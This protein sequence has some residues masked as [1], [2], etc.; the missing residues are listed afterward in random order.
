MAMDAWIDAPR[1]CFVV[2]PIG[3]QGTERF[4]TFRHVLERLIRPAVEESSI[5]LR[6]IRADDIHRPG[7]F[8]RDV[9]EYLAGAYLVVVDLTGQNANVFYELGVRHALSPRT[10]LIARATTDIPADLR[11]Y[12]TLIYSDTPESDDTF[13]ENLR[14]YLEEIEK[15]PDAPDNPVLSWLKLPQIPDD[16][17]RSFTARLANA[18]STQP[19]ILRFVQNATG[20]TGTSI[21]QSDLESRFQKSRAEMY[22]RLEQL[23][24]LGFLTKE[25]L[26]SDQFAYRLA[27]DYRRELGFPEIVISLSL[28]SQQGRARPFGNSADAPPAYFYYVK[29]NNLRTAAIYKTRIVVTRIRLFDGDGGV[30][31]DYPARMQLKWQFATNRCSPK[32]VNAREEAVANLGFV[33]KNHGFFQLDICAD[34]WPPGFPARLDPRRRMRVDLMP[35]VAGAL[36]L[37]GMSL[38]IAWDGTWNDDAAQMEGNLVIK[39]VSNR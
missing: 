16:L 33:I 39:R 11:E 29:A 13:R 38:E 17:R 12:R 26:T 27:P 35:E 36:T 1:Q 6:V 28:V 25:P 14:H 22:Y 21:S 4:E 9:L 24:L 8:I 20:A 19:E 30:L 32:D 5:G 31:E 34:P 37:A 15:A 7:S 10:I 3:E 2:S 23:R 18:G